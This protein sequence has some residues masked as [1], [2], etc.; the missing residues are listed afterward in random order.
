MLAAYQVQHMLKQ[1]GRVSTIN[2][3][4]AGTYDP[5]TGTNTKPANTTQQVKAYFAEY[6]LE[7]VQGVTLGSRFVLIGATDI[8]GNAVAKPS[9]DDTISGIDDTVVV[10]KVQSIYSGE[11]VV[12]YL[13]HARE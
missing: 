5:A 3:A 1:F 7:E 9:E 13:C 12:C 8:L 6:S 2:F 10:Y 4:G 11:S